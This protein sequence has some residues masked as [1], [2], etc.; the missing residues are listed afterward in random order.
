M[1]SRKVCLVLVDGARADVVQDLLERGDLP[2]LARHVVEPGGL[3]VGTSVFPSTTGVA[4]LPFL[5]GV[6]PGP[7]NIPRR[8]WLDR[9]GAAASWPARW[10]APRS[11][12][13]GTAG[14]R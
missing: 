8:R 10:R 7:A 11:S 3:T 13:G 12:R 2:N 4:Y 14:C 5:Y 9:V 1:A 6:Y